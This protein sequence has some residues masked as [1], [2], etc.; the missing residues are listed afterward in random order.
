MSNDMENTP[1]CDDD[2]RSPCVRAFVANFERRDSNAGIG[3]ENRPPVMTKSK[4]A[5]LRQTLGKTSDSVKGTLSDSESSCRLHEAGD[6]DG[7]SDGSEQIVSVAKLKENLQKSVKGKPVVPWGLGGAGRSV[8]ETKKPTPKHRNDVADVKLAKT[9]PPP[10]AADRSKRRLNSSFKESQRNRIESSDWTESFDESVFVGRSVTASEVTNQGNGFPAQ[11]S[12]SSS[13]DNQIGEKHKLAPKVLPKP[14]PRKSK[15]KLV[16]VNHERSQSDD[17][18]E[19]T[20]Y[21]DKNAT[22]D[23]SSKISTSGKLGSNESLLGNSAPKSRS[24]AP[25]VLNPESGEAVIHSEGRVNHLRDLHQTENTSVNVAGEETHD[26]TNKARN[27]GATHTETTEHYDADRVTSSDKLI[28]V[29][30]LETCDEDAVRVTDASYAVPLVAARTR[31]TSSIDDEN[32]DDDQEVDDAIIVTRS[33]NQPGSLSDHDRVSSEVTSMEQNDHAS[34]NTS[35]D[36]VITDDESTTDDN[37]RSKTESE[38]TLPSEQ[39]R[40]ESADEDVMHSND[41]ISLAQDSTRVHC[42][43]PE[44]GDAI[45][46]PSGTERDESVE[47]SC[48]LLCMGPDFITDIKDLGATTAEEEE[49]EALASVVCCKMLEQEEEGVSWV[50]CPPET[51]RSTVDYVGSLFE[52]DILVGLDGRK[53]GSWAIEESSF[54]SSDSLRVGKTYLTKPYHYLLYLLYTA[55]PLRSCCHLSTLSY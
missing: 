29:G 53:S 21:D 38:S 43:L 27:V 20:A 47:N 55:L 45:E 22:L 7:P 50:L 8:K 24:S 54:M 49:Y 6:S 32:S 26:S 34:S 13:N 33:I 41:S 35:S 12:R 37:R 2:G 30:H 11:F 40:A 16:N 42:N 31:Y 36:L 10:N 48:F 39:N 51:Y 28:T 46:S 14:V 17:K 25:E 18:C 4:V 23:G 9:D 3:N 52:D 5:L 1:A 44:N 15:A 19:R